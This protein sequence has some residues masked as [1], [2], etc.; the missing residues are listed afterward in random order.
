MTPEQARLDQ[1][2][3]NA[4]VFTR[5]AEEYPGS[6]EQR[7]DE[8]QLNQQRKNGHKRK[9]TANQPAAEQITLPEMLRR[10]VQV[11]KGPMVIDR[12]PSRNVWRPHEFAALYAHCTAG[13]KPITTE[14]FTHPNRI[15]VDDVTFDPAEGEYPV[16][17]AVRYFNLWREPQH[18]LTL[19]IPGGADPFVDH[20]E[21]LIPDAKEA[22][23]FL[24]YLAHCVQFPGV[25]PHF[26]FLLMTSQTGTGRG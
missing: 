2:R 11:T 6:Q 24:D 21:Y 23:D 1:E 12:G 14:W 7:R 5:R 4:E 8:A 22:R 25:R 10:F 26:H 17:Q 16:L 18:D 20:I 19:A 3:I 15:V 13:K 9:T